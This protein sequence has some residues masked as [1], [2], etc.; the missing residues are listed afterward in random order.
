MNRK[1][2]L[3]IYTI[4]FAEREISLMRKCLIWGTGI[5]F[6]NNWKSIQY[7]EVLK[8]IEVIGITSNELYYDTVLSYKFFEKNE[9]HELEFDYL[10]VAAEGKALH[11]IINEAINVGIDEGIVVPIKVMALPGFDFNKY[12]RIKRN[13]PTIFS[14]SCWGGIIYNILAL[15]FMSPLINMFESHD[16]YLKFL[17][18][19]K[20]YFECPL[21][22]AEHRYQPL[23]K[24]TYPVARCG[25]ILLYFNHYY[26]FEEAN[27][28]WNRRKNRVNWENIIVMFFDE[29]KKNVENFL[30]LQYDNKI[31]ITPFHFENKDVVSIE[32]KK[33]CPNKEFWQIVNG[34]ATGEN[35]YYDVFELLSNYKIVPL[36]KLK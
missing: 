22:L 24:R 6:I 31:C 34:T 19:P 5:T 16:D 28:C 4:D 7:Y 15:P 17:N 11:S 32:Y 10:I 25:D 30:N 12:I 27:E 1:I 33:Y 29:D 14:P 23:L 35:W 36:N 20:Y 13:I 18:N 3:L 9:I 2:I 26:S 8:E 21:E